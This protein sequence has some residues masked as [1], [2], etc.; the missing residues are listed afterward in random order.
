MHVQFRLPLLIRENRTD[1]T[2]LM[3]TLQQ[4]NHG[5]RR[6]LVIFSGS[7]D[8]ATVVFRSAY[9]EAKSAGNL[10]FSG[11]LFQHVGKT[12][13]ILESEDEDAFELGFGELHFSNHLFGFGQEEMKSIIKTCFIEVAFEFSAVTVI[14]A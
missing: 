3:H 12:V 8:N 13:A 10:I 2:G 1:P 11:E 6:H 7:D 4:G 9:E 14:R 5:F